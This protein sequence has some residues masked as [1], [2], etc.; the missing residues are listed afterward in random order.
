[1]SLKAIAPVGGART[2]TFLI[3][4][5]T[6][7]RI[8]RGSSSGHNFFAHQIALTPKL[9]LRNGWAISDPKL[10]STQDAAPKTWDWNSVS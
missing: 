4:I 7:G 2:T 1:M 10:L 3:G 6:S 9:T 8:F 5:R